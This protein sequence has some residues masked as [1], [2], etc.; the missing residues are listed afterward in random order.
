MHLRQILAFGALFAV[1]FSGTVPGQTSP[2]AILAVD[3]ANIVIISRTPVTRPST[4]RT[5]TS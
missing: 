1:A 4:P 3:L 2:T 5:R